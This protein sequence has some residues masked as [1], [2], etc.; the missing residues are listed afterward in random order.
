MH[1]SNSSLNLYNKWTIQIIKRGTCK[2]SYVIGLQ[3]QAN[4]KIILTVLSSFFD[5]DKKIKLLVVVV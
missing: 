1:K 2:H 5:N 3:N 4:N